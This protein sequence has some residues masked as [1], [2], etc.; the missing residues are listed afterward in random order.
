MLFY[1]SVN[2][3]RFFALSHNGGTAAY[4]PPLGFLCEGFWWWVGGSA[5]LNKA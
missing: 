4:P 5:V 3:K 1:K 2:A